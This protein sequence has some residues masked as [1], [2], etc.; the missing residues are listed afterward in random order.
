MREVLEEKGWKLLMK[1][2]RKLEEAIKEAK[3]KETHGK[4]C[5]QETTRGSLGDN[6]VR[7]KKIDTIERIRIVLEKYKFPGRS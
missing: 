7:V 4:G 1:T 2:L 5:E 6:E 3:R